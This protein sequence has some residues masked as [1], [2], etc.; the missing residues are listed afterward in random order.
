ML[1]YGRKVA[2]L[3]TLVKLRNLPFAD[4]FI[5]QLQLQSSSIS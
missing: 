5:P 1:E 4:R 3:G 2:L